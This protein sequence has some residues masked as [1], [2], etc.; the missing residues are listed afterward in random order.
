MIQAAKKA[1]NTIVI[2]EYQTNAPRCSAMMSRHWC[3]SR[4]AHPMAIAPA[5]LGM[6]N[7]TTPANP[8][9]RM[10]ST[11]KYMPMHQVQDM[12]R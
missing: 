3:S 7:V 6:A 9:S 11:G 12:A 5:I 2:S 10:I 4:K 1:W 8:N